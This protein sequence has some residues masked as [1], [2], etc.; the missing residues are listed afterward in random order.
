MNKPRNTALARYC[1]VFETALGFGGVVASVV[2]L[3]E[4]FLP[5]GGSSRAE[6]VAHI[7]DLYPGAVADNPLTRRAA[8]LL[9]HY[10][11]GEQVSFDLPLDW[12]AFT[13]FQTAVY[14]AVIKLP[15]GTTRSYG[16]IARQIGRQRAARGVGRAMA[17]NPLP[18]VI[19]CHRVVGA[20][21]D[22]T[23]YSGVGGVL[24]KKWLLEME[25]RGI[26]GKSVKKREDGF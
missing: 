20:A 4:V 7:A 12:S 1:S 22:L 18:I 10:F 14:R 15:A 3:M 23:G 26:Q 21:G 5:F 11:A 9:R 8:Q 25:Q 19:P 24:S 6:I 16:E 17:A 13:S 2:G